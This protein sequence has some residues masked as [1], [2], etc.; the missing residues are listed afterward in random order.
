MKTVKLFALIA[1]A[2]LFGANTA[3]ATNVGDVCTLI[4]NLGD[5]FKA[6]RTL[7]FA[8][9]AFMI[10]KWAWE[11]ITKGEVP[12]EDAKKKSIALLVGFALLFG[13]A[14]IM[15]FLPNLGGCLPDW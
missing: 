4:T 3:N 8:G 5:V 12:L 9:A 2:V 14:I 10:M 15:N 7:C 13:I 1:L 11:F 6:L